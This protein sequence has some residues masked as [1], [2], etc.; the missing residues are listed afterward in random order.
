MQRIFLMIAIVNYGVGNLFSLESSFNA[1]GHKVLVTS[2]PSDLKDAE[3]I[4]LPGV[5]AFGD[6]A[7]KLFASGLAEPLIDE[8]KN[9][10]PIL[11]ICLGMQLL[12]TKSYEFGEF[13]G[14]NLIPGT[15]RPIREVIPNDLKIP[16]MGWNSLTF[17]NPSAIY[18]RT[19]ENSYVYFVHSYYAFCDEKYITATTDYGAPLTASVQNGNIYGVQYHPEKSGNV[20]LDILRSF[21]EVG[22]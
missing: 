4:I 9:G 5:G 12:F 18:S 3:R 10:K 16:Q 20:G 21:C 2:S 14:L 15:V 7:E 8:A 19:P 17:T 1:I 22:A 6:A 11:G 13:D